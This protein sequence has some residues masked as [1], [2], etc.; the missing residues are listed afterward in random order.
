[1]HCLKA[2]WSTDFPAQFYVHMW[3]DDQGWKSLLRI[4]SLYS[5]PLQFG[6]FYAHLASLWEEANQ[7]EI[8]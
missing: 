8:T 2:Q 4:Q 6:A 1:M 7:E 3:G 5:E